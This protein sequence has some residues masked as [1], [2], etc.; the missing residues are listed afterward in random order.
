MCDGYSAAQLLLE[1]S[2]ELRPFLL[3]RKALKMQPGQEEMK[4]LK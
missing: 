1:E 3:V 2:L 4:A